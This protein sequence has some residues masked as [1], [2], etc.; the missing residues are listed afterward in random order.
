MEHEVEREA[1]HAPPEPL[2]GRQ[3]DLLA[4][5]LMLLL[6]LISFLNVVMPVVTP[7]LRETYSFS[8]SQIGLLTSVFMFTFC[9]AG[10]PMGLGAARWGGRM[11]AGGI[12]C[13][14][15]GS[16]LFALSSSFGW[17]LGGRFLQGL[18]A[19][20]VIPVCVPLIAQAIVPGRRDR[21]F[22]IFGAGMGAGTVIALLVLPS[23]QGVGGYRAVFLAIVGVALVIGTVV[24]SKK[25][26]RS[27]PPHGRMGVDF[28]QQMKALGALVRSPRVV[29]LILIGTTTSAVSICLIVWTPTFLVPRP[30]EVAPASGLIGLTNMFGT[31]FAPWIFGVILDAYGTGEGQDGY[32]VAYL[33]LALFPLV[34]SIAAVA[35][36]SLSRQKA[37]SRASAPT[38]EA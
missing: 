38:A 11:L 21:A 22:G 24:L 36:W 13:V 1:Q 3:A 6:V 5:A 37:D 17:F 28:A 18:G 27:L 23:I 9:A 20:T 15:A 16:V 19:A 35:Y 29:L 34:G 12:G 7:Q 4:L 25:A 14:V 32:L 33:V 26:V 10:L 30:Q 31:V 2:R 8:S